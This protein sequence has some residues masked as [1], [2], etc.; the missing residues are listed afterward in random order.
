MSSHY[1]RKY[2]RYYIIRKSE[3]SNKR[4]LR[5]PKKSNTELMRELRQY[6][7][8]NENNVRN[9]TPTTRTFIT[10]I[11]IFT[12]HYN[13][14]NKLICINNLLFE[15]IQSISV[16]TLFLMHKDTCNVYN[17]CKTRSH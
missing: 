13:Y 8:G 7:K 10:P 6:R 3:K 17:I 1:S 2:A 15:Q 14:V 9:G 4:N 5:K 11:G 12:L 16:C